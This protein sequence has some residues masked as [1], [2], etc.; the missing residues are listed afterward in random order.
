MYRLIDWF[1]MIYRLSWINNSHR[2]ISTRVE[3]CT[4]QLPFGKISN[5]LLFVK[6]WKILIE[7]V[8]LPTWLKSRYSKKPIILFLSNETLINTLVKYFFGPARTD[9]Y[10]HG[11]IPTLPTDWDCFYSFLDVSLAKKDS[12]YNHDVLVQ[13]KHLNAFDV[14]TSLTKT[15]HSIVNSRRCFSSL[16]VCKQFWCLIY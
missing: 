10:L 9:G 1:A 13:L 4:G 3:L 12:Y 7:A 11:I 14:A 15:Y 2:E 6:S 8:I 5:M 16:P